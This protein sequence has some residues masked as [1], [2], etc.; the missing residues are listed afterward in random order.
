T[1][2]QTMIHALTAREQEMLLGRR[3]EDLL[4]DDDRERFAGR[5]CVITGAG[6]SVGSELARQIAG[7]H[8]ARLV[9]VEHS[10]QALFR[11]EQTLNRRAPGTRIEPVLG[12]VTRA[13]SVARLMRR[14]RPD[15]VFHAAAYKHVTMAERHIVAAARVN[16]LGTLAVLAATKEAGGRFVFISS[17]KAAAP[18]SVMGATKRFAELATLTVGDDKP[19]PVI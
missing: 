5:I 6:G 10:E 7:C 2:A 13:V 3:I 14:V 16:V 9:L 1:G 4:G 19:R 12:D 11:V 15:V 17:D 18:I 8:P